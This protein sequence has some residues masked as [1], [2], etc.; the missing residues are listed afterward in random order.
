[1]L[2]PVVPKKLPLDLN[3]RGAESRFYQLKIRYSY[4]FNEEKVEGNVIV[5]SNSLLVYI[6]K[7][8]QHDRYDGIFLQEK[9]Q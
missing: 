3:R 6:N 1:M 2:T 5:I 7:F 9:H 4:K 8:H